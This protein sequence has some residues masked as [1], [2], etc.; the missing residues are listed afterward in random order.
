MPATPAN[1]PDVSAMS[2]D[3]FSVDSSPKVEMSESEGGIWPHHQN[4]LII[5]MKLMTMPMTV[6]KLVQ[7]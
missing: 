7:V 6:I 1:P 3:D 4:S 5:Q 2:D